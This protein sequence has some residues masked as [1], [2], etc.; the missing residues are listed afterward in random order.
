MSTT[1]ITLGK[2]VKPRVNIGLVF[3]LWLAVFTLCLFIVL[4]VTSLLA[5]G[6]APAAVPNEPALIARAPSVANVGDAAQLA[7]DAASQTPTAPA[8]A[9]TIKITKIGVNAP[10]IFSTSTDLKDLAR[11]LMKGAIRYPGSAM[12]G[13]PGN[14]FIAGH[15]GGQVWDP[16]PYKRVFAKLGQLKHGDEIE[17]VS[18]G[19]TYKYRV[20]SVMVL[21]PDEL[22]VFQPSAT[23]MLTLSTCW[24]IGTATNRFVVEADL[25]S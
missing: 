2:T 23:A 13:G 12:P 25:I 18:A 5:S 14:L 6:N 22:R 19:T 4:G 11:D 15:S 10:L 20:R 24:P 3:G 17:I 7:A 21:R 1:A 9:G 16:N 8:T